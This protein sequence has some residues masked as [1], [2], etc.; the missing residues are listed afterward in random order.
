MK[1]EENEKRERGRRRK[2]GWKEGGGGEKECSVAHSLWT[3]QVVNAQICLP[4]FAYE[5][6]SHISNFS[7]KISF[8]AP[9]HKRRE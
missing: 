5:K 1:E 7:H 3:L 4:L 9:E 6:S 8:K 2:K